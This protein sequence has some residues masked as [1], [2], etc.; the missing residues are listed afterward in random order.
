MTK[1]A[2]VAGALAVCAVVAASGVE[3]ELAWTLKNGKTEIERVQ[4]AEK[5]GVTIVTLK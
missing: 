3:I 1:K 2:C 4:V 5:D